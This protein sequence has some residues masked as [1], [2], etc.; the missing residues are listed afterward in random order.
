MKLF[1][2]RRQA[3]QVQVY[4]P[5]QNTLGRLRPRF[6]SP[7]LMFGRDKSVNR[8]AAPRLILDLRNGG[9]L[10]GSERLPRITAAIILKIGQA[11]PS[12]D[13]L[14]RRGLVIRIAGEM[15]AEQLDEI[16]NAVSVTILVGDKF[17]SGRN[18]CRL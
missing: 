15:T 8:I 13:N 1:Q 17:Q 2:S 7:R 14:G 12:F 6:Q 10:N 3:D 18:V 5:E 9:T 11:F 4:A 16:G